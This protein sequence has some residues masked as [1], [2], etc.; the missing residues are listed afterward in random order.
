MDIPPYIL[1]GRRKVNMKNIPHTF[2]KVEEK[3]KK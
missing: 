3:M 2:K 1:E